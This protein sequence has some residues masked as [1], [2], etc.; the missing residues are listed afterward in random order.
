MPDM[1]T[2]RVIGILAVIV[3]LVVAVTVLP[4]SD[5]LPAARE[6]IVVGANTAAGDRSA[7][8]EQGADGGAVALP[9]A[10][11]AG[12]TPSEPEVGTMEA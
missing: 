5:G 6:G 2:L 11:A 10:S 8:V 12:G 9:E 4:S 3:L 7:A 1:K